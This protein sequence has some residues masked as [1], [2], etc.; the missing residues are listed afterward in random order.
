VVNPIPTDWALDLAFTYRFLQGENITY[1]GPAYGGGTHSHSDTTG[2]GPGHTH[3][4]NVHYHGFY[5][6]STSCLGVQILSPPDVPMTVSGAEHAHA[7]AASN[8]ATITYSTDP[9][10]VN[11][12]AAIP[13]YFAALML[14]PTTINARIPEG[15]LCFSDGESPPAGYDLADS[16]W[17]DRY[18]LGA[19]VGGTTGGNET[20]EHTS[21]A[22]KHTPGTHTHAAKTCGAASTEVGAVANTVG[23]STA[24]AAHHDVT[25]NTPS[26]ALDDVNTTA[27]TINAA[28]ND[29]GFI[30]L[31]GIVK[32]ASGKAPIPEGVILPFVGPV[33]ELPSE[34]VLCDG[35]N[36]TLDCTDRQVKITITGGEVG[37]TGG[38]NAHGHTVEDHGHTEA[39]HSNHSTSVSL[40]KVIVTTGT[41]YALRTQWSHNHTWYVNPATPTMQNAV[42][43]ISDTDDKRAWYRTV[44][45]VKR[46]PATPAPPSE[47]ADPP[48]LFVPLWNANTRPPTFEPAEEGNYTAPPSRGWSADKCS[49]TT[50]GMTVDPETGYGRPCTLHPVRAKP[51]THDQAYVNA[52]RC[53]HHLGHYAVNSRGWTVPVFCCNPNNAASSDYVMGRGKFYVAGDDDPHCRP[54]YTCGIAAMPLP[55]TFL[56]LFHSASW[57]CGEDI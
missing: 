28:S 16:G 24:Y 18:L 13:P 42:I 38:S 34:W 14:Q 8:P 21:P 15:A 49:A 27:V 23:E 11:A 17:A 45:W 57:S 53:R 52:E 48:T 12:A 43:T 56:G 55:K 22:H 26:P 51:M 47:R 31:L 25:L 41:T 4:G 35:Q 3:A 39:A 29:P 20:H 50:W 30:R 9:I 7:T 37:D 44:L 19:T 5:A 36:G 10:T 1:T 46:V 6:G 33:D 32:A 2:G 54:G 40:N